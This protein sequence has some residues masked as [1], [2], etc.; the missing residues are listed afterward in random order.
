MENG[1]FPNSLQEYHMDKESSLLW[2]ST[3]Y[4]YPAMEGFAVAMIECVHNYTST[5]ARKQG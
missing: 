5:Y 2:L 1:K 4:I 3:D